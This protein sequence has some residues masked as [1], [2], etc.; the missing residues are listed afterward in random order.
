MNHGQWEIF[1][2]LKQQ[3]INPNL[4][5]EHF[6]SHVAKNSSNFFIK[7][8]NSL[9]LYR[10]QNLIKFYKS[11]L[12]YKFVNFVASYY[13]FPYSNIISGTPVLGEKNIKSIITELVNKNNILNAKKKQMTGF[14]F[15][16]MIYNEE[17]VEFFK[18]LRGK[19][20]VFVGPKSFSNFK[21]L[22][23]LNLK[24]IYISEENAVEELDLTIKKISQCIKKGIKFFL[25]SAGH[26]TIS[27]FSELQDEIIKNNVKF[28]DFGII[29]KILINPFTYFN[30]IDPF[31]KIYNR[32]IVN[33]IKK[34]NPQL[35]ENF[36]KKILNAENKKI[37]YI[38]SKKIFELYNY[39]KTV[40][41]KK[42]FKVKIDNF[43]KNLIKKDLQI[44]LNKK[45]NLIDNF[46]N[47]FKALDFKIDR[48]SVLT[49]SLTLKVDKKKF[50]NFFHII[51]FQT[52]NID[53]IKQIPLSS[54]DILIY[55]N[56]IINN[57]IQNWIEIRN[58]CLKNNKIFIIINSKFILYRP[59]DEFSFYDIE[60][61]DTKYFNKEK[62]YLVIHSNKNLDK[63]LSLEK[64]IKNSNFEILSKYINFHIHENFLFK[65]Q[66]R[67]ISKILNNNFG[68]SLLSNF[69]L[70][71]SNK[72]NLFKCPQNLFFTH[73]Y[74]SKKIN[75]VP[76]FDKNISNIE[77]KYISKNYSN[78]FAINIDLNLVS[79]SD[80]SLINEFN[81]FILPRK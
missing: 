11:K 41:L 51:N 7:K 40:K 27:I 28:Y 65:Y 64:K 3:N 2:Y 59:T 45:I 47:I 9:N 5:D 19:K 68:I 55:D 52:I 13:P 54:W 23:K 62:N 49:N 69:V 75:F 10:H 22:T 18:L 43:Y 48:T 36:K 4:L 53:V 42:K 33:V 6:F 16:E 46:N 58:Y 77:K 56:S 26:N 25:V 39:H 76:F 57:N 81:K 14:E 72:I 66:L 1:Y 70:N 32:N 20:T 80:K 35:F 12:N 78:L 67:R 21:K 38:N 29:P 8:M 31:N 63:N 17:I 60:I 73:A 71:S 24:Q 50:K 37:Y 61:I 30:T 15:R 74:N 79:V 34:I 44:K